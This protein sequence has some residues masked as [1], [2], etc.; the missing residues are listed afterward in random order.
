MLFNNYS[1]NFLEL[2]LKVVMFSGC[3]SSAVETYEK[4]NMVIKSLECRSALF[5]RE[6]ETITYKNGRNDTV[7]FN[8][9]H[10]ECVL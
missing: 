7:V 8:R 5:R 1:N 4:Q 2:W 10:G 6:I 9:I 3:C